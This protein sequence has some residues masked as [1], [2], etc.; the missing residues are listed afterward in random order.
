MELVCLMGAIAVVGAGM[1]GVMLCVRKAQRIYQESLEIRADAIVMLREAVH[2][3]ET[4]CGRWEEMR[5]AAQ[6]RGAEGA[7][8]EEPEVVVSGPRPE[9]VGW[10]TDDA[11][12]AT[13]EAAL[14]RR[15]G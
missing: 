9:M 13:V 3:W 6:G 15:G 5:E 10:S 12:V 2:R 1:I 7:Q 4:T 8:R 14:R 11:N